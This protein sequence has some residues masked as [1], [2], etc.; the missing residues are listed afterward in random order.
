MAKILEEFADN[1]R[2]VYE[3]LEKLRQ[4]IIDARN[5][6][7]YGLH[8]KKQMPLFRLLRGEIFGQERPTEG[9]G[10]A[11][12]GP[13]AAYGM[14]EEERISKLVALTQHVFI[15]IERELSLKGFWDSIPARQKL[16]E[17]LQ[18]ILLQPEFTQMPGLVVKRKHII[19]RLMET[20]KT[21]HDAILYAQ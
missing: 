1:W 10:L 12:D 16:V 21:H 20:A 17:S 18:K 15:E 11:A 2:K 3:E 5:E 7:T 6:P 9:E 14:K 8:L 13:Q 19:S 4:R